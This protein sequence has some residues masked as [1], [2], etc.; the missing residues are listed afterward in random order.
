MGQGDVLKFLEKNRKKNKWWTNNEI[1]KL[2]GINP[3]N[4]GASAAKLYKFKEIKM[5]QRLRYDA[6]RKKFTPV[7]PFMW[8]AI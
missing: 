2:T 5:K 1:G 4:I 6:D 7:G 8:K 3:H